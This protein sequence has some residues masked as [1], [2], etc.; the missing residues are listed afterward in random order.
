MKRGDGARKVERKEFR[1]PPKGKDWRE[2]HE[3]EFEFE[4]EKPKAPKKKTVERE[5]DRRGAPKAKPAPRGKGSVEEEM[6]K[7]RREI[8]KALKE[9]GGDRMPEELRE[10]LK[11]LLK[12]LQEKQPKG[13]SRKMIAA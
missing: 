3:F 7:A 6:G 5:S 8:E 2:G 12:D 1:I 10:E 9:F 13:R 11:E 4:L